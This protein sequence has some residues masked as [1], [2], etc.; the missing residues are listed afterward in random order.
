MTTK[1]GLNWW[2]ALLILA[3]GLFAAPAR[4]QSANERPGVVQHRNNCRLAAQVLSTG[5]P[6]TK[7][8]W[9]RGYIVDCAD[10][11][12]PILA[13]Q[14]RTVRA[15]T[16]AVAGLVW[17]SARLADSRIYQQAR[18][19]V[20]DRSKPDVVR[21]GA[22]FVLDSYVNPSHAATFG[23]VRPPE[24]GVRPVRAA[25]GYVVDRTQADGAE[26]L[27]GTVRDEVLQL[28]DQVA[29][30]RQEEPL[31]VWYAAAALAKR[32]RGR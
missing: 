28:L 20:L 9:A 4:A 24:R 5:E 31:P 30:R 19:V 3:I 15:D 18:A 12:P 7:A 10:E 2:L 23:D 1:P 13:A 27:G 16:G 8:E 26:P 14:W 21:V 6:R 17:R 29:A 32:I 25:A 22:M 11:G